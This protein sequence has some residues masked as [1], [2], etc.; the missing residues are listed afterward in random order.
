[1]LGLVSVLLLSGCAGDYV[2]RTRG[3]RAAY[4]SEDY[5][6]ALDVLDAVAREGTEKDRLLVLLDRGMV[7]HTAGRWAESN[8]VLEEA[9]KLS[10]QLDYVSVGEEAGALLT[11][12]RQRSYR[13]EDFEKLMI[14]VVQALN[15]AELGDDEAAMVE[16]RQVNER[17]QKMVTDEKKPY[18]QLAIARY[19]GG[20]IRED[21]HD[22]DSAY[23][24]Y[25]K[26]YEL[27]PRMG[28]LVEPLLRLA[29]KTGRDDAYR[30][31]TERYPDIPHT[32]LTAGEAQ[33]V[34]VVEAGLSPEKQRASRDY[35]DGGNLIEVP[36]YRDRGSAPLVRVQVG[37]A[38]TEAMT[39]TSLANVARLHLETRIGGMLAKQLA[40][41][42]VKA[43]V[44]AG[45]GALTKS[46][47]VGALA[48]LLLN[49]NNAPDLRSWLSL[50]AEFQVAR[51]RVAPGQH[52][53]RVMAGGR[54][55][56]HSVEV[57]AGRV[58]LLVVRRY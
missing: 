41:V 47:G 17:L 19:L 13:G 48:F 9:E 1:M 44:A 37:D 39:V 52:A 29:K 31:L 15:Y 34:V 50:P 3:V 4:Q 46:E 32:P 25:A 49:A 38:R 27:S 23:I 6:H 22:W 14:S 58:G 26:A 30:E 18:E 36:V 8:V 56:V 20:V 2:A 53:V 55:T 43:G 33:V 24:D 11:N 10:S 57:Q 51:F 21:Q 40:G 42:A 12:E 54:E 7:L 16:V 45:V 35:G 5:S 28:S